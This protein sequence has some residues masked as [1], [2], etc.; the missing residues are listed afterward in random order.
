MNDER[1][2][3]LDCGWLLAQQHVAKLGV[4]T[5]FGFKTFLVIET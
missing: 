1:F 2:M 5:I 3:C 4:L